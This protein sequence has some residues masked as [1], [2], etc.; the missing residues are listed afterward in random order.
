MFAWLTTNTSWASGSPIWGSDSL[1]LEIEG[2]VVFFPITF[3]TASRF[4]PLKSEHLKLRSSI[5]R[6]IL[7]FK[8]IPIRPNP[9]RFGWFTNCRNVL[10]KL[11]ARGKKKKKKKKGHQVSLLMNNAAS[12]NLLSANRRSPRPF[13]S[14]R[15]R[16]S[17][18]ET[19]SSFR[20]YLHA[21]SFH[22]S[23]RSRSMR[24][25]KT[26]GGGIPSLRSTEEEFISC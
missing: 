16:V 17:W 20:F 10:Y 4:I 11:A 21:E 5:S 6:A 22:A 18:R 25:C 23:T 2:H 12:M 7:C 3:N 8:S 24:A 26:K 1:H 9:N 14:P 13:H 15:G 19:V